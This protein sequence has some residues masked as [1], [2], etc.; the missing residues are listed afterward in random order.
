MNWA[1]FSYAGFVLISLFQYIA[2][3][4]KPREAPSLSDQLATIAAMMGLVTTLVIA[5]LMLT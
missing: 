2:G 3:M 4:V 1:L 5:G